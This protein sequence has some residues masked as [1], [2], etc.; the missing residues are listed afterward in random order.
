MSIDERRTAALILDVD[1]TLLDSN[2]AH[3]HAWVEAFSA[4]GVDLDPT[5]I[6]PHLGK[7]G[8]LLVPDLLDARAMRRIGDD[9]RARKKEI[10]GQ[11]YL[12]DLRPF[13]GIRSALEKLRARGIHLV[14]ATS[15][16]SEELD[17][18]L[19]ILDIGGLIDGN[20]SR[21]D[22]SASK[23]VPDVFRAAL[24]RLDAPAELTAVVGDTPYDILAA[25]R[26]AL[27]VVA[28][29]TGGFPD[30]LLRKAE[31]IFDDVNELAGRI[32]ELD[33]WFH[34]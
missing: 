20:T 29:R 19:E 24:E 8:D 14:L 18:Y 13:P 3:A 33:E 17:R 16:G 27:P 10:F 34:E 4:S 15:A 12:P 7:G 1:G 25:H 5:D 31:L 28:V 26:V 9:V 30:E 2:E 11:K 32:E 21:S 6:R 23:P 22:V